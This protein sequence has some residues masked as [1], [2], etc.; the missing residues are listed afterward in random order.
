MPIVDDW[1]WKAAIGGE[2]RKVKQALREGRN[3]IVHIVYPDP[4]LRYGS[5]SYQLP[6]LLGFGRPSL[7]VT[8]FGF[9]VTGASLIT[10]AGLLALFASAHQLVITD[11]TLLRTFQ[12]RFPWWQRKAHHGFVGSIV[13]DGTPLW[14]PS[15]LS[16]RR[17]QLGLAEKARHIAFFG[18]WLPGKGLEELIDA[19][20]ILRS[21][22]QDVRLHLIGGRE[23]EHRTEYEDEVRDRIAKSGAAGAITETGPL[24]AG[25]VCDRLLAM[26]ACVLP[27]KA[28]P[29]GR[30]SLALALTLGMPTVA[31]RP[32]TGATSLDGLGLLKTVTAA[33]IAAVICRLLDQPEAQVKCAESAVRLSRMWSWDAIVDQYAE[34]YDMAAGPTVRW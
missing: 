7:V 28:N 10:K 14:S 21:W 11:E 20:G 22:G 3:E 29:V 12:R 5:D 31:T 2:G 17:R 30:S 6:F 24:P 16:V 4:Y 13:P 26:D 34:L 19:L 18:F 9:A 1:S 23:P 25:E 8:F 33:E 32:D 15:S 27:F